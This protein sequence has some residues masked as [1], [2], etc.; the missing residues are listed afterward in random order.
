MGRTTRR[1]PREYL[2]DYR[3]AERVWSAD[4][5]SALTITNYGF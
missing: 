2:K 1:I 3:I 5:K 4:G